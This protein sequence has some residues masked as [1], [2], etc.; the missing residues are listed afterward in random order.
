MSSD[1]RF[2]RLQRTEI[3]EVQ[4]IF[5]PNLRGRDGRGDRSAGT[6]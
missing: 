4:T 6:R 5:S 2:F 1:S 3:L